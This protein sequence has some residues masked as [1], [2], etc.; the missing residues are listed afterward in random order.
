MS[1]YYAYDPS[2][3]LKHYGILGMR[4]GVRRYQNADGSLTSEGKR[5][6]GMDA[7]GMT[8]SAKRH[9]ESD[10]NA[11][12]AERVHLQGDANKAKY[13]MDSSAEGTRGANKAKYDKWKM[14]YD[15]AQ[16][17]KKQIETYIDGILA[18][19]DK[20]GITPKKV[21]VSRSYMRGRDYITR[22]ALSGA[23][24][25][26]IAGINPIGF[27]F[28]WNNYGASKSYGH[29]HDTERGTKYRFV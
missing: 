17:E 10:L 9:M 11:L 23:M 24:A 21:A 27:G 18:E 4:W 1:V 5:R 22:A 15:K 2:P 20:N 6:Y 16:A 7:G 14:E 3:G 12:D 25:G 26:L 19:A 28:G 13:H 8:I 29:P